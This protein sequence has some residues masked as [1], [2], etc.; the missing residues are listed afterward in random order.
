M[1][2][3][4]YTLIELVLMLAVIS[5]ILYSAF[6]MPVQVMEIKQAHSEFS[7][8]IS[9]RYLLRKTI[10]VDLQSE[11]V[12]K[13][14]DNELKIGDKTY[15]FGENDVKKGKMTISRNHYD[16]ELEDKILKV[17][18]D[19]VNLE[20]NIGTNFSRGNENNE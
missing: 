19:D 15:Y 18:N 11:Y 5:T 13:V 6:Y 4:G 12:E 8:E 1:N 16:F 14:S 7:Q 20:F 10:L 17:Y 2:N 3:K 9:D